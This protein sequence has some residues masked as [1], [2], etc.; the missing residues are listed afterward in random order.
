MLLPNAFT[1]YFYRM[2]SLFFQSPGGWAKINPH[3][4]VQNACV[5]FQ[6]DAPV[7]TEAH[8]IGH[9]A[10]GHVDPTWSR[11][12]RC[13][14]DTSHSEVPSSPGSVWRTWRE[15]ESFS[16]I[17]VSRIF[18]LS[19]CLRILSRAQLRACLSVLARGRF[20]V[21]SFFPFSVLR[22]PAG[23]AGQRRP[24]RRCGVHGLHRHRR[25]VERGEEQRQSHRPHRV[26]EVRVLGAVCEECCSVLL[27]LRVVEGVTCCRGCVKC[28]FV[29]YVHVYGM[30]VDGCWARNCVHS[31]GSWVL[32][33]CVCCVLRYPVF[34]CST[35]YSWTIPLATCGTQHHVRSSSKPSGVCS[36]FCLLCY[37]FCA[38][39]A[40]Q[41]D[42]N[43]INT[44]VVRSGMIFDYRVQR[45]VNIG[46]VAVTATANGPARS[47]RVKLHQHSHLRSH[48]SS[49]N[50]SGSKMAACIDSIPSAGTKYV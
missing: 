15:P 41:N 10:R 12:I 4:H 46:M 24:D 49:S 21:V 22:Q 17:H 30:L 35:W 18:P 39:V 19:I 27:L 40:G 1:E 42:N 37:L 33:M 14:R 8:T 34:S 6:A 23:G 44:T 25:A 47:R 9:R 28:C 11:E 45:T 32:W 3:F 26:D 2:L 31:L 16:G 20:Y 43:N 38:L 50:S 29:W 7:A 36:C 48:S 13:G 5:N